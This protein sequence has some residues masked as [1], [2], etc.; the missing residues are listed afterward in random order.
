MKT[1]STTTV[2]GSDRVLTVQ[3]PPDVP[4]E[5]EV[6]IVV[7]GVQSDKAQRPRGTPPYP[8]AERDALIRFSREEIYG[9][10]SR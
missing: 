6:V 7:N 9:D 2:I 1:I 3:L 5:L 4:G 8:V 10:N